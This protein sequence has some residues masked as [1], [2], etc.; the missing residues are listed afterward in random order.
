M[1]ATKRERK[2]IGEKVKKLAAEN[3]AKW[4]NIKGKKRK[5]MLNGKK[6]EKK[7]CPEKKK[8]EKKMT[9]LKMEELEDGRS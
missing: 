9:L 4:Y 1:R 2:N 7:E 3:V 5:Q 6:K 8:K